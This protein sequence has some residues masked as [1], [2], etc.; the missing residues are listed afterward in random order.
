[1]ANRDSI[2]V[3]LPVQ[4]AAVDGESTSTQGRLNGGM[5][6]G[7]APNYDDYAH[8]HPMNLTKEQQAEQDKQGTRACLLTLAG[9]AVVVTVVLVVSNL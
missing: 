1:M 7:Y 8:T 6:V 3:Q 4:L 5:Y 2:E 9:L